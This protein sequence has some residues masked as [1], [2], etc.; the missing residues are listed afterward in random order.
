MKL[1]YAGLIA[2]I[3]TGCAA[4]LRPARPFWPPLPSGYFMRVGTFLQVTGTGR[5]TRAT[6]NETQRR[7]LSRDAAL[8][9]AWK[10]MVDYFHLFQMPSGISV[11]QHAANN[12]LYSE[13]LSAFVHAAHIAST[14]W[15]QDGTAVVVLRIDSSHVNDILETNYR[16]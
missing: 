10:R 4:A 11:G 9:D 5:I 16:P 13:R 1:L 15:D 2:F 6:E 8:L 7:S 12:D 3:L 14:H